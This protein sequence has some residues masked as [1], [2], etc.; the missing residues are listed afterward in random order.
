MFESNDLKN[1]ILE[2]IQILIKI[3]NILNSTLES[4][5]IE[6]DKIIIEEYFNV[7][8]SSGQPISY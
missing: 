1:K 6:W 5:M 2:N 8:D 3:V 7:Y 4:S